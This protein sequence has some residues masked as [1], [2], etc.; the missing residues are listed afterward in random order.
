MARFPGSTH[1]TVHRHWGLRGAAGILVH[2]AGPEVLLQLRNTWVMQGGTWSVPGGALEPGE[3][4]VDAALR[5]LR[6]E[7]GIAA[8]D[9]VVDPD[10][11]VWTCPDCGWSY[12][13][14][15]ARPAG[16]RTLRIRMNAEAADMRWVPVSEVG[17]LPLH[18]GFG[19][20]WPELVTRLED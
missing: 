5:E 9:V 4:P 19:R 8:R 7:A 16:D 13:T 18:P 6:E 15:L 2:R 17:A 11:Q 1:L 14:F 10:P 20:S 12:W 3:E